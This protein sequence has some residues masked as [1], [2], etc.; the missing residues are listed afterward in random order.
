[1]RERRGSSLGSLAWGVSW[2]RCLENFHGLFQEVMFEIRLAK[3]QQ[4][5]TKSA[6]RRPFERHS[7]TYPGHIRLVSTTSF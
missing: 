3:S 6:R 4:A 2:S 1:M 7:Q 5:P